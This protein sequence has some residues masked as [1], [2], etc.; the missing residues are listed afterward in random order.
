MNGNGIADRSVRRGMSTPTQTSPRTA[1][2]KRR[3]RWRWVRTAVLSI[4]AA[5][6]GVT[7]LPAQPPGQ[8]DPETLP[9]HDAPS[10][11]VIA[12][13]DEPGERLV[14]RGRVFAPDGETP[15]EGVVLY[16]YQTDAQGL[17]GPPGHEVPRLRGWVRT[18]E[19]GRYEVR[20]IRPGSYPGRSVPEHVHVFLWGA[21]YEPQWSDSLKF[22]DDP[23]LPEHEEES[24]REAGRFG[25]VC[26][27]ERTSAGELLCTRNYR[28]KPEG[29]RFQEEIR[30]GFIG[31][32]EDG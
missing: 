28:L 22:A 25:H 18:D 19:D 23:L 10:S 21:G 9:G 7:C 15:E 24:S 30:H 20:T 2:S 17:Y 3:P 5:L 32:D 14:V 26:D 11:I 16:H 29:D 31:P 8:P 27:P 13:E 6:A 1:R 4:A 12:P